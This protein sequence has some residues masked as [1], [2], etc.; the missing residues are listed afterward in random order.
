MFV[1]FVFLGDLCAGASAVRRLGA[2]QL[3]LWNS[4]MN[5]SNA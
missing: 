1:S 2:S 3:A 4:T 5:L